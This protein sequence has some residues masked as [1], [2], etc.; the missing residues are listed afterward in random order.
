MDFRE[1]KGIRKCGNVGETDRRKGLFAL[2][3]TRQEIR[4]FLRSWRRR[5]KEEDRHPFRARRHDVSHFL[6]LA[7]WPLQDEDWAFN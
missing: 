3:G 7:T 6:I 2:F 4:V 5:L 1:K